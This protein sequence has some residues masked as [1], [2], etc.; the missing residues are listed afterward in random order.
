MDFFLVYIFFA[1]EP[2]G[3]FITSALI[4]TFTLTSGMLT[5]AEY[6]L[7]V[8][9]S[10]LFGKNVSINAGKIYAVDLIGAFA[11]AILTAVFLLPVLGIK[12]GLLLIILLKTGSLA[13]SCI[14]EKSEL[15]PGGIPS[16]C[17]E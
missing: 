15:V 13:M 9:R 14:G 17:A 12:N 10:D 4:Y 2:E 6:P 16:E 11:G 3:Y 5:G 1:A 7:A 8:S